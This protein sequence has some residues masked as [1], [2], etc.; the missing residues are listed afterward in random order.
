MKINKGRR[1]AQ[2]T[3]DATQSPMRPNLVFVSTDQ[4]QNGEL[5][6]KLV[7]ITCCWPWTDQDGETLKKGVPKKGWQV[8]A[9]TRGTLGSVSGSSGEPVHER[10]K[11]DRNLYETVFE[12]VCQAEDAKGKGTGAMEAKDCGYV[13][14]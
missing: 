6:W 5:V 7:E 11:R 8:G 2:I 13:G 3:L 10:R 9:I 14:A 4:D 1:I 12:G